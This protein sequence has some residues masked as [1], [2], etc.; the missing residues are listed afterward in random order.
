MLIKSSTSVTAEEMT[1]IADSLGGQVLCSSSR[2]AIVY[3]ISHFSRN[4]KEAMVLL[5]ETI[6]HPAFLDEELK[7]VRESTRYELREMQSKPETILPE[8]LHEVAFGSNGLGNPLVCPDNRLD[9]V[10]S[11]SLRTFM[12]Q[13]YQPERLVI[14]GAGIEHEELVTLAE[15]RFSGMSNLA[16]A[17]QTCDSKYIGGQHHNPSDPKSELSYIY[18][19][20]EGFP[21]FDPRIYTLAV[22]QFLLGGGGSF[23][24]GGPGK[25]M[26]SR[27][28]TNILNQHPEIDHCSAFHHIYS[29]TSLFGIC[30]NFY[31]NTHISGTHI[32]ATQIL[33]LLLQ[34]LRFLF[35]KPT[36][37][38]ELERAKNQLKSSLVMS[39]ESQG[40]EVEDLGR[41]VNKISIMTKHHS[42]S[43]RCLFMVA[44]FL[45]W[46]CA[47]KLTRS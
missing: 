32:S 2:E 4:A 43:H 1:A 39:L 36:P 34:Q 6:L 10:D 21:I 11:N 19:G 26:Y 37:N 15:R 38:H 42:W 5:S 20:F 25:G 29:D 35:N 27:L 40:I 47:G 17:P 28:Y 9:V 46:K 23:S 22:I 13:W 3:Q 44:G 30:T 24:A 8:V 16:F 7:I 45:L 33:P 41:Q 31:H 14:A 18:L 12:R